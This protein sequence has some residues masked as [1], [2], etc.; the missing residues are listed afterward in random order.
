MNWEKFAKEKKERKKER[1]KEK[2]AQRRILQAIA[3]VIDIEIERHAWIP[4]GSVQYHRQFYMNGMH[5]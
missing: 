2:K 5:P 1:K 4:T 3:N